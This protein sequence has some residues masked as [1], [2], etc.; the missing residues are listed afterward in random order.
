[1]SNN[2]REMISGKILSVREDKNVRV[3]FDENPNLVFGFVIQDSTK[4][5]DYSYKTNVIFYLKTYFK[6]KLK[7]I[8]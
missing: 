8:R 2:M 5:L 7:A 4:L 1:M 6:N 3:I